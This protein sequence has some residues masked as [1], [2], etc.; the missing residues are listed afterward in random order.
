MLAVASNCTSAARDRPL[1]TST[2]D[3]SYAESVDTNSF[4]GE[5]E[6]NG[7]YDGS[8]GSIDLTFGG[9]VDRPASPNCVALIRA[10]QRFGNGDGIF[11]VAEQKN[12]SRA[13]YLLSRG[14]AALTDLPRRIRIGIELKL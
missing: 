8:T 14:L 4:A 12:A 7:V 6:A 5:A 1:T 13:Q 2:R 11:T 3:E 9:A 10:E